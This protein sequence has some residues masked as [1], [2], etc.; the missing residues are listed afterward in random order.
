[1]NLGQRPTF[2]AAG[3]EIKQNPS[4]RVEA[5]A[6]WKRES[7]KDNSEF[8]SLKIKLSKERLKALLQQ[9]GDS[10]DIKF[11]AFTNSSKNGDAKRPDFR[12]YEEKE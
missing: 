10:V 4:E 3:V 2:G 9:E 1:M 12:V 6:I 8:L 5:G 7:R 11:V